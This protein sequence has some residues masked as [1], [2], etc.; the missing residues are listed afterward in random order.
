[1]K[2][3]REKKELWRYASKNLITP[4][5]GTT[6]Q[7]P[8]PHRLP[9]Q[10]PPQRQDFAM[11]TTMGCCDVYGENSGSSRTTISML[12]QENVST[13]PPP[14]SSVPELDTSSNSTMTDYR[15]TFRQQQ[16][17]L[18][19]GETETSVSATES[20][21]GYN[22]NQ[23][24]VSRDGCNY[25]NSGDIMLVDDYAKLNETSTS[26]SYQLK[27]ELQKKSRRMSPQPKSPSNPQVV[28]TT[29]TTT[30]SSTTSFAATAAKI[31][32]NCC[33]GTFGSS[34][35]VTAATTNRNANNN[36]ATNTTTMTNTCNKLNYDF[37]A[38]PNNNNNYPPE[39]YF[40]T[41]MKQLKASQIS[42]LLKAVKSRH[43]Q[44]TPIISATS[45]TSSN[46]SSSQRCCV[47]NY[48]TNC[49]LIR[50]AEILGEEPYVIACRLFLWRD[51]KNASELKRLPV[52]PNER[53]PVYVCCNPLHWCRILETGM[54]VLSIN[55]K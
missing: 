27:S 18:T 33:G 40:N 48:Q 19:D 45:N 30:T 52:C 35:S 9:H 50:R 43:D 20:D 12:R 38:N 1:M 13:P 16:T 8:L 36:N 44:V 28:A 15:Q 17:Y 21:T 23:R 2:Y 11:M 4:V 7:P 47:A 54:S 53:D 42:S 51:L 25:V 6:R 5:H 41:L 24:V 39:Q 10:R 34:N 55:H 29:T 3:Q 22:Q 31:L 14:Y 46:S 26:S 37:L 32:R 49:I